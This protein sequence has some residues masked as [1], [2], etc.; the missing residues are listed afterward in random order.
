MRPSH[1]VALYRTALAVALLIVVWRTPSYA[2][3]AD[4][5]PLAWP[6]LWAY[7]ILTLVTLWLAWTD[8]WVSHSSR[9]WAYLADFTLAFALLYTLERG[10]GGPVGPFMAFYVYL[11]LVAT[12]LWPRKIVIRVIAGIILT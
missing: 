10:D 3:V 7:L 11:A 12:L 5:V 1:V 4:Q 6:V 8:W 9:R 2:S